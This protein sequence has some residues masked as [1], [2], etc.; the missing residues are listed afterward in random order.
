M[1]TNVFD[2]TVRELR[3]KSQQEVTDYLLSVM[4]RYDKDTATHCVRVRDLAVKLAAQIGFSDE[5]MQ[6][7]SIA[8]LLHDIG[9]L[10]IPKNILCKPDK[11][12]SA[13]FNIIKQHSENGYKILVQLPQMEYVA[14]YVLYHHELY[15]GLGYPKGK[16]KRDIPLISR[17]LTLVDVYESITSDRVYRRAMTYQ[18]A[19]KVI[20]DGRATLFDPV[21]VDIFLNLVVSADDFLMQR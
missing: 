13:E 5:V 9:K 3:D 7:V 21:L 12:T 14:E 8:A 16:L 19:V 10:T 1:W 2:L 4:K 6:E 17:M 15:N 11:L 20:E 18:K